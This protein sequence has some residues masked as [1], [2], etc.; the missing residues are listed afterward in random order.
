MNSTQLETLF[1]RR[2]PATT[3]ERQAHRRHSSDRFRPPPLRTERAPYH[4]DLAAVLPARTE[5]IRQAGQIVLHMV[6]DTGGVNGTGAQINVADHMTRQIRETALPDQPSFLYHLGD[7]VYYHG[8]DSGY[9]DQFYHPYQEYP[10]PIFAIPGNHDGDTED[11][12]DTLAPFLE[13]FCSPQA[14]HTPEAGHSDRPTMIQPNCYWCLDAPCVTLI[15]LYSNVSGEL[16][17]TDAGDTTQRD[18]LTEELRRAPPGKCLLVAVHHP[19]YSLG[20][21][22]GTQR[23]REALEHAMTASGRV[24]DAVLTAHDHCY[25]RFTRKLDGHRLPILVVGAG[26]FAGYDDLTR[27]KPRLELPPN[28]KLEASNDKRPGFLTLTIT[29]DTLVGE[30]FTVRGPGK[31]DKSARRRDKFVLDLRSHRLA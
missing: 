20:K 21:H 11:P 6:G 18:W 5:A 22:G 15:G 25:Q 8:Q 7:V 12:A 31:E 26:G 29:R 30:Y 27:I 13:H 2:P 16:D 23:V 9:H 24:P 17:H 4:L 19:I 10:A 14:Q 28:V 1:F 3:A